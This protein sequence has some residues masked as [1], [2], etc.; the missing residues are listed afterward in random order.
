AAAR[1]PA[2]Q[3]HRTRRPP[4]LYSA[5]THRTGTAAAP[6]PPPHTQPHPTPAPPP[7]AHH[8]PAPGP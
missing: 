2:R 5:R 1:P 6:H 7:A 3:L 4:Q 8:P